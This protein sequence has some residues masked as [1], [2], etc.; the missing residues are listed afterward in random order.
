MKKFIYTLLF[1]CLCSSL[2][3]AQSDQANRQ[4]SPESK[5]IVYNKEFTVDFRLHTNGFALGANIGTLNTYYKTRYYH[6]E[7]G[8]IHHPKE[9][10]QSFDLSFPNTPTT[11]RSF[12][13]GKQN[14]FF[15]L[16]AGIGEKRYF[17]EK[18]R[19]RGVA[20]GMS[21]EI[22]PSLG[23][24]KPYYLQLLYFPED[25]ERQA[26]LRSRKYTEETAADFLNIDRIY[27]A[28]GFAEGFSEL[29]LTPG[30][31]GKLAVHFDWGAFD[32]FVK[33]VEAGIM[34]D[35]Y[36]KKI[37][38]MVEDPAIGGVE[39]RPFFVNLF[40]NFQLGKRW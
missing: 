33:A 20:V 30:A 21:Y 25:L 8:E 6:F 26:E 24:L 2:L 35:F 9:Y 14:N 1:G 11:S 27:G 15:V 37:P 28:A 5:G 10:R 7:I 16:R 29:S 39:N 13:Y 40:L 32:E 22:G 3:F 17:S 19:K 18:A 4:F 23:I 31:Q 12:I 34:V 36:F 38:L